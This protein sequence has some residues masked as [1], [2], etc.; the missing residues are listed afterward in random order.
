MSVKVYEST[1]GKKRIT[2]NVEDCV[3]C[4]ICVKGCI[5]NVLKIVREKC[6]A[7]NVDDCMQCGS[8]E[9]DCCSDCITIERIK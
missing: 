6:V 7:V 8:C 9:R 3:G 1:S 2:V 5:R 4:G